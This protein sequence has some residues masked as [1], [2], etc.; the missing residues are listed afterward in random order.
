LG[1][2]IE[3]NNHLFDY[4]VIDLLKASKTSKNQPNECVLVL[5]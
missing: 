4:A 5:M 2:S 3:R 1:V